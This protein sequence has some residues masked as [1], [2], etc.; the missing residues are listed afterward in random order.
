MQKINLI[1]YL[2]ESKM[3]YLQISKFHIQFFELKFIINFSIN[4]LLD[5]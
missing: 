1:F 2:I 3:I 4:F 5:I